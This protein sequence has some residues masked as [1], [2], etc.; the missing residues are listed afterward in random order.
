[1]GRLRT[2]HGTAGPAPPTARWAPPRGRAPAGPAGLCTAPAGSAR[3]C[4]TV[5]RR[6]SGSRCRSRRCAPPAPRRG[7]TPETSAAR[8]RSRGRRAPSRSVIPVSRTIWGGMSRPRID[9]CGKFAEDHPA[10]H[11]D[12]TDLGDRVARSAGRAGSG[13][14]A[15]GLEVHD[16]ECGG[17]QRHI[18]VAAR[19]VDVGE[20]Q[21]HGVTASHPAHVRSGPRQ[22]HPAQPPPPSRAA[23][24]PHGLVGGRV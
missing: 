1:M 5:R 10:A 20:A 14:P 6:T 2:P 3:R 9:E 23:H 12:R 21:L 24:A 4:R 19:R 8:R 15:G 7:R 17:A 18:E 22:T 13:P 16:D 11:F